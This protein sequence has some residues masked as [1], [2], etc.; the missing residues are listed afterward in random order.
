MHDTQLHV[1]ERPRSP[2]RIRQA[3]EPVAAHHQHIADATVA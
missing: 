2:G 3:L 1:D